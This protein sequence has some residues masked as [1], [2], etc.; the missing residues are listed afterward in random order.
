[1][2]IKS[3]AHRSKVTLFWG[4]FSY[5]LKAFSF[6]TLGCQMVFKIF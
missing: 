1:L 4:R 5:F 6:A 2:E 3:G